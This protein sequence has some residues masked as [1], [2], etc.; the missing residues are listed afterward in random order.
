MSQF[1]SVMLIAALL[2]S[3]ILITGYIVEGRAGEDLVPRSLCVCLNMTTVVLWF[4]FIAAHCRD[5]II[6]HIDSKYDQAMSEIDSG[7]KE[8]LGAIIEYG[9]TRDN[10]ARRDTMHTLASAGIAIP[11]GRREAPRIV[12]VARPQPR[13]PQQP[14]PLLRPE[15]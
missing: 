6:K 5:S 2:T 10:E 9:D 15:A 3:G 11:H 7:L 14:T 12:G 8:T 4:G 13:R 1:R